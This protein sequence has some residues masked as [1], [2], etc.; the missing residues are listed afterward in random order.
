M[1]PRSR[2]ALSILFV[3]VFLLGCAQ[4]DENVNPVAGTIQSESPDRMSKIIWHDDGGGEL[5]VN[6]L[7]STDVQ[8]AAQEYYRQNYSYRLE[9]SFVIVAEYFEW[10]PAPHT[11][12]SRDSE[13]LHKQ[14]PEGYTRQLIDADTV[15]WQV[16]EN[17]DFDSSYHSAILSFA[18]DEEH[19]TILLEFDV[20]TSTPTGLRY[21]VIND[22][23]YVTRDARGIPLSSYFICVAGCIAECGVG[24]W[25]LGPL[26]PQCYGIC[27]SA[28]VA[29]CTVSYYV[30][31]FY[32][33]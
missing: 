32:P 23:Q 7:A 6:N 1:K 13:T 8:V 26:Y 33:D 20:S 5:L 27:V 19:S 16:F 15:Y 18:G 3:Y 25:F 21:G 10:R 4:R 12:L 30:S 9:N 29:G 11:P 31:L 22:G 24:C 28:C 14:L 2:I 17:P